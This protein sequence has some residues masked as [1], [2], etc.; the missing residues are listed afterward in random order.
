MLQ[1][2][3][4]MDLRRVSSRLGQQLLSQGWER[5]LPEPQ[6]P[7]LWRTIPCTQG[8]LLG[9]GDKA[10]GVPRAPQVTVTSV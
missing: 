4:N 3:K 2:L 6:L 1:Q 10:T 5:A 9:S 8:Q 7:W